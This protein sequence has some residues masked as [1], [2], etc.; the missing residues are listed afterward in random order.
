[1][2]KES[3]SVCFK[4]DLGRVNMAEAQAQAVPRMIM[5]SGDNKLSFRKGELKDLDQSK[6][7]VD[8]HK[9]ELGFVIRGALLKSIES[10]ELLVTIDDDDCLVGFV[11]YRHRLDGQTTLYNIVVNKANRDRGIGS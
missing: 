9:T 4:F 1:M 3:L 10:S 6:Q 8:Q 7:L 2:T 5:T 11:Q